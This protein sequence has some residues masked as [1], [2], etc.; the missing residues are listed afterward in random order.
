[1][2]LGLLVG[3]FGSFV[4]ETHVRQGDAAPAPP[5]PDGLN[6]LREAVGHHLIPLVLIARSDGEFEQRERDV[7]VTH[8][9]TFA[10]SRGLELDGSGTIE[11]VEYIES[12]RPSLM[13]LDPALMR[14]ERGNHEEMAA[15]LAAARAVIEADGVVRPEETRFLDQLNEELG[16]LGAVS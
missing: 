1:M 15:L 10:R 6:Q 13:Q 12:Y 16:R 3:R 9:V 11:F 14:L 2:S 4:R 5:F 7:I 8:C